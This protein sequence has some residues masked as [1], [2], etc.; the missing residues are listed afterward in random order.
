MQKSLK[1]RII[2][3]VAIGM[4]YAATLSALIIFE[5]NQRY[6]IQEIIKT[7]SDSPMTLVFQFDREFL[8]LRHAVELA[9]RTRAPINAEDL[10]LRIDIASSRLELLNSSPPA[11]EILNDKS[12]RNLLDRFELI[13]NQLEKAVHAP[14]INRTLLVNLLVSLNEIE[15]P[16]QALSFYTNSII[17][18]TIEKQYIEA[19]NQANLIIILL[20]LQVVVVAIAVLLFSKRQTQMAEL[21]ATLE[22]RAKERS[23]AKAE[24]E[25]ANLAKSMFL[26]AASHDLQQPIA[27][28]VLYTSLLDNAMKPDEEE[29]KSN[30]K[31]CVVGLSELLQDL[32]NISKIESGV[33]V[34]NITEF[35]LEVLCK[36]L[37]VTYSGHA[38]LK[39]LKLHCRHVPNMFLRT[40]QQLF[41]RALGNLIDNAL[42]YTSNGGVLVATRRRN[43]KWW[44]EVWDTGPGVIS[45]VSNLFNNGTQ[46]CGQ[47]SSQGSGLGLSIASKIAV[48]LN[49]EIRLCTE[50]GRGSVFA[51]ELP[52]FDE[53]ESIES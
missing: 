33:M 24:A 25:N 43:N 30:I 32:L 39:G 40:D 19:I 31:N 4:V 28:L 7:R 48:V 36:T 20:M 53:S 44:V 27:A 2:W 12:I 29:L 5:L 49:L 42:K 8:R 38:K 14:L 21:N 10:M 15:Q 34:A 17:G 45:S 18:H 6:S 13:N 37:L 11:V 51:V 26:A 35:S 46:P 52:I 1:Q 3:E 9:V 47:S 16:I 23:I 50:L 22:V 41:R